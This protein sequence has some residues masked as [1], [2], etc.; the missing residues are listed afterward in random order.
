MVAFRKKCYEDL[1]ALIKK[2][3]NDM[4]NE[5]RKPFADIHTRNHHI[6]RK[7]LPPNLEITKVTMTTKRPWAIPRPVEGVYETSFLIPEVNYKAMIAN[8]IGKHHNVF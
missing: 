7:D 8:K 1:E 3:V 2:W 6:F 5:R 4:K